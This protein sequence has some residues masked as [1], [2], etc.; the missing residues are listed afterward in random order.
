MSSKRYIMPGGFLDTPQSQELR[1]IALRT[2]HHIP[3][4]LKQKGMTRAF[5]AEKINSFDNPK[6]DPKDCPSYPKPAKIRVVNTETLNEAASLW[7]SFRQDHSD[8]R[9]GN[10]RPFVLNFADDRYPGGGW[11]CGDLAQ[12]EELCYRSTLGLSLDTQSY[13]LAINEGIYSPFVYLLRGDTASGHSLYPIHDPAFTFPEVSV[14]SMAPVRKP[15]SWRIANGKYLF[16]NDADCDTTKRKMRQTLRLAARM[17]H[18]VLVLGAFG[19]GAYY[20]PPEEI[21]R[22][23]LQ[24]LREEE[25]SGN[26]WRDVCFALHDTNGDGKYYDVFHRMLSG[27][28]V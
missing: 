20:N 9:L 8:E 19:C 15:N 17:G 2:T 11:L 3:P 10:K 5:L 25:F 23:W 6:L 4:L 13:P 21:A 24:V 16:A 1:A 26:W 12:E 18:R 27:Q 14:M 7:S 28:E 22:L